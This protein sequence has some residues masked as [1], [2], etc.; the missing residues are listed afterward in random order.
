MRLWNMEFRKI[1]GRPV[2]NIG[3]LL[4]VCFLALILIQEAAISYSEIDGKAYQGLEA[5][6]ADRRLAKEYEGVFTLEKAK[7]IVGRFG[8]S[9]YAKDMADSNR[10]EGNYCSQFVTDSMTDFRQ[11][12]KKPEGFLEQEKGGESYG[13]FGQSGSIRFGYAAGWRS[14]REVWKLAVSYLNIWL[15]AM[16]APVFSEEYSRKTAPILLS[17][18]KGK[19][20]GIC[21]KIT[22][23]LSLGLF[24]YVSVMLLLFVLA[25]MLFGMDGLSASASLIMEDFLWMPLP[26]GWSVAYMLGIVF[27]KG[28]ASVLLHSC[29]LLFVSSKCQRTVSSATAGIL[30][31]LLPY[32]IGGPLFS[33]LL[34]AGLAGNRWGWHMLKAMRIF[35]LSMPMNLPFLEDTVSVEFW[36]PVPIVIAAV[37][38]IG[39]W[40][41]YANY[42]DCQAV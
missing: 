26:A 11:T 31:F 17:T 6:R 2:M 20:Q 3:F 4:L 19:A 8:F 33:M 32:F 28:M 1:A 42:R 24:C 10:R 18:H 39:L 14:L 35:S 21:N 34:D 38:A 36:N 9:G 25:A 15:I 16:L 29:I 22:A 27:W 13:K 5:I 41:A 12:G 30:L 37:G 7:E 40:R 23:A